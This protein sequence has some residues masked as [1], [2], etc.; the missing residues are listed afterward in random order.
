MLVAMK[1]MLAGRVPT[2]CSLE[3]KSYKIT[4]I[5]CSK[6]GPTHLSR[7]G[8]SS[9]RADGNLIMSLVLALEWA[10]N[11]MQYMKSPYMA[12]MASKC[13]GWDARLLCSKVSHITWSAQWSARTLSI[14]WICRLI[15]SPSGGP[16]I[17]RRAGKILLKC[18]AM[19]SYI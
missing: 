10:G 12:Q 16:I 14:V 4:S 1:P 11:P 5:T 6:I 3:A 9:W 18:S 2:S 17:S 15:S 7:G 19:V 8:Q 13:F